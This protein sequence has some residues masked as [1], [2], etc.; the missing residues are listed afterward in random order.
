MTQAITPEGRAQAITILQAT[1]NVITQIKNAEKDGY[2]ALQ[3]AF[4]ARTTSAGKVTLKPHREFRFEEGEFKVGDTVSVD[5]FEVGDKVVVTGT[6]KGRGFAGTIKRHKF[7]SGPS[8][9]GHDH[10]RAPGS[11]GPMGIPRVQKGR[12][13][14][15]HMGAATVTVKTLKVMAVDIANNLIAVSGAVPGANK[16]IVILKAATLNG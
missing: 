12:R 3:L 13:M 14:S 10:H 11:I 7:H 8:G 6:S 16:S 4:P 2:F 1:P 15:G 5:M 9:H